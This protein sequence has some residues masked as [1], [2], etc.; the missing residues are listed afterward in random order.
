VTETMTTTTGAEAAA[1]LAITNVPML[2]GTLSAADTR[3]HLRK[4]TYETIETILVL[5]R[6]GRYQGIASLSTVLTADDDATLGSLTLKRWPTVAPDTD[7]EHAATLAR[8]FRVTAIPVVSEDKRPLGLIPALALLDTLTQEH[9]EDVHRLTGILKMGAKD[10]H[11]LDD[12]PVKRAG[13]R[14][15]W[16]L[17]GLALSSFAT[18]LMASYEEA[19]QANVVIAFF[20]PALVYLADAVGTQT[21][22]VVVRGL[23]LEVLPLGPLLLGELATGML[24]GFPLAILAFV[25]IWLTFGQ[26]NLAL[27]VAIALFSASSIASVLG[28]LLPWFLARAGVDPAFGSGPVA[29]I[30]QDVLT[31][32]IYFVVMTMVISL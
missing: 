25:G 20:I 9:L 12:P 14:L 6:S 19:L 3:I 16:L 27:G 4:N 21:E 23:S 17:V 28:L 8:A 31:I 10:R 32:A 30:L 22:A 24:I 1:N 15:P 13:R 18:L 5:D 26:A 11:A 7:Q 29:T 2:D